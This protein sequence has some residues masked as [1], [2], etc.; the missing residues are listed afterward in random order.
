MA[1][2]P[3][4]ADEQTQVFPTVVM[5]P[6]GLIEAFYDREAAHRRVAVSAEG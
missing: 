1:C 4:F 5:S 6:S 2:T 3:A